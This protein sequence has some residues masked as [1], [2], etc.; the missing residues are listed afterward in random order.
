MTGEAT[1]KNEFY[2]CKPHWE[3]KHQIISEQLN[4]NVRAGVKRSTPPAANLIIGQDS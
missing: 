3:Q 4:E 2:S 1:R